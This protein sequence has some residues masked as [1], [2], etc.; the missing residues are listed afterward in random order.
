M[1]VYYCHECARASGLVNP[2]LPM[3]GLAPT[4]GYTLQKFLEHTVSG[5]TG[6]LKSIFADRS[7]AAYQDFMVDAVNS[8]C[9]EVDDQNRKNLIV[10]AGKET[11]VT[12]HS[13]KFVASCSS[14]K[15]VLSES[16]GQIHAFPSNVIAESQVCVACGRRVPSA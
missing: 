7:W 6:K 15:V 2:V 1:P 4:S 14:V 10:F 12:F 9:L 16:S 8:G 11:G 3:S 13:G 5:M